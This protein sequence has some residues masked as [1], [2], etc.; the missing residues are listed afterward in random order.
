MEDLKIGNRIIGTNQP[1]YIIAE[2]G[3]NHNGRLEL[4]I[5][6]VR[7]AKEIG[8]DCVKF[9]TFRTEE[10]VTESAPKA[11]YQLKVTDN[12]ESQ[13]EM[14]RKLELGYDDFR[15][16]FRVCLDIGIDFLSTP[17]SISDANFLNDLN[18]SAFKIASGQIVEPAFL[19]HIAKFQ[20]PIFLSTGMSNLAEVAEAVS[21]IRDEKNNNIILLQCNTNY[22]SQIEDAN[23][24]AMISMQSAFDTLVGYSDH[25]ENNMACFA[26]VALGAK[27]IEK[28]FTLD[29]GLPGPDHLCSLTPEDF[30]KLVYGIRDVEKALGSP[31]KR[32]T[33]S[34]KKNID[35]MRRSV[36]AARVIP[37]GKIIH[38]EDL[39]LKRPGNGLSPKMAKYIIGK[40]ANGR[41]EK[42]ALLDFCMIN[43]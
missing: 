24:R 21:I 26:A 39:A 5:E 41:I 37:E 14:L 15:K 16:V 9:Q 8:A 40:Q 30:L 32:I 11:A 31:I 3:V 27:V 18:V 6:S 17:Y 19:A 10:V 13:A 7:K 43:W 33:A 23:I 22:P 34:E 2:V 4:A 25:V 12:C 36:V 28:H 29:R 20:K 35:G 42:D 38:Q 1:C